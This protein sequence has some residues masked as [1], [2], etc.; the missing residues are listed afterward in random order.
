LLVQEV[1][2]EFRKELPENY[3]RLTLREKLAHIRSDFPAITHIDYSARI[4]TVHKK[5]N[6]RYW[7]LLKAFKQ[8]TG[9]GMLV[10][11]SFNVRGE[12]I[13]C[14]PEDAYRCFMN[15]EMDYLVLGDYV[16]DKEMQPQWTKKQTVEKD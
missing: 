9:V 13:V 5:T 6:P 2:D 11:T 8:K 12:P 3:H 7:N 14:T 10:N 16:F 1:K 15:T 4:Q